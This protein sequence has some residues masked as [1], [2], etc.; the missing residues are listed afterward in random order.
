ME[1]IP[2]TLGLKSDREGFKHLKLIR[3][4]EY[5]NLGFYGFLADLAQFIKVRFI[6]ATQH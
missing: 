5:I 3:G 6:G 2:P 1:N 4:Q